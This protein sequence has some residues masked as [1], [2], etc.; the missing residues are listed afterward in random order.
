ME[1]GWSC[2]AGP[3]LSVPVGLQMATMG[4]EL[5]EAQHREMMRQQATRYQF[6][7]RLQLYPLVLVVSW[8]WATSES[9]WMVDCRLWSR[10]RSR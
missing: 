2:D 7:E 8:T 5:S 10:P 3:H 1:R 9:G 4:L 6:V